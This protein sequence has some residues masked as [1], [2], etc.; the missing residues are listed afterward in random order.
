MV[1]RHAMRA[2]SGV[3]CDAF[4]SSD[5]NERI[6]AGCVSF[7]CHPLKCLELFGRLKKTLIP[8][9]DVVIHFD[10][11]YVGIGGASNNLV[12]VVQPEAMSANAHI[13]SP[14]LGDLSLNY[15]DE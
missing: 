9:G 14:I 13:V 10:A 12:G 6:I 5:I 8:A 4:R 2:G 3:C 15:V 7:L 11:E 1:L